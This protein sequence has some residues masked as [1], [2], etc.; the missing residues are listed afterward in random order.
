MGIRIVPRPIPWI[1]CPDNLARLFLECIKAIRCRALRA[2]VSGD[3]ARD[4]QITVDDRRR[5]AA[6]WEGEPAEL[7]HQRVVPE[8]FTIG[9]K[10][11]QDALGA[12]HEDIAG[13][14]IYRRARSSIALIDRIAEKIIVEVLPNLLAC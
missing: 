14:R 8:R 2:P 11:G 3:A 9:S 6:V 1:S 13:F 5:G 4:D 12:L 7:F 10:G